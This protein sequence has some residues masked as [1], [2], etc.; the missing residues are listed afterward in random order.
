MSITEQLK[1]GQLEDAIQAAIDD[2]KAAPME[3]DRRIALSQLLC[4]AGDLERADNHLETAQIQTPDAIMRISMYRQMIRG[5]KT[6]REC[7]EQGRT[8]DLMENQEPNELIQTNLKLILALRQDDAAEAAQLIEEIE[9]KRPVVGGSNDGVEFVDLR[10]LDDRTAFFFEV[11]TSNGKYFWL[12]FEIVESVE[13][14]PPEQPCDLLWRRATMTA[15]GQVGDVFISALYPGSSQSDTMTHKLGQSTDWAGDEGPAIGLGQRM[16]W[17]GDD[18]KSIM[19]LGK[20]EIRTA[21][22]A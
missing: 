17:L 5:E 14:H 9:E 10:D 22:E 3:W 15:L 7:W 21:P 8:P 19:E 12:P 11:I 1:A 20:L 4:L 16:L 13:F 6:R 18:E 2:V